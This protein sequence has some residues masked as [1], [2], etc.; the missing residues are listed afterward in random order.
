MEK[1]L[2]ELGFWL[3][4]GIVVAAMIV[5][6]AIKERDKERDRQASLRA[7]LERKQATRQALLDHAGEN[8]AEVLAYLRE[9]DAATAA[10]VERMQA[11]QRRNKMSEPQ[12]FAMVA[13]FMV[14]GF[15]FFGGLVAVGTQAHPNFQ[16]FVYSPQAGRMILEPPPPPPTGLEAYAPILVMLGIWAT[17]LIVAGLIFW[18]AS[19]KK[20]DAQPAG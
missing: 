10:N 20:H 7:D 12:V 3:A 9:R 4:V 6:G 15:S 2:G 5:A 16:R 13:A 18:F 8:I 19:R 11:E 14:A 17:G 1:G